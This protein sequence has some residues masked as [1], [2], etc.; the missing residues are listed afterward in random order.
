MKKTILM[1]TALAAVAT[2]MAAMCVAAPFTNIYFPG[3]WPAATWWTNASYPTN[4]V[5][6]NA[7]L[8]V[9]ENFRRISNALAT[10]EWGVAFQTNLP[11]ASTNVVAWVVLTNRTGATNYCIPLSLWP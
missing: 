10:P 11:P 1:K 8:A 4:V 7:W 5:G 6:S 9:Q 3:T 2:G